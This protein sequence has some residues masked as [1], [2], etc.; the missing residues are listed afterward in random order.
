[1]DLLE[2][3]LRLQRVIDALHIGVVRAGMGNERAVGVDVVIAGKGVLH[4]LDEHL[5]VLAAVL[6][7]DGHRAAVVVQHLDR[8]LQAEHVRPQHRYRRAAAAGVHEVEPIEHKGRVGQR[9]HRLK[10]LGDLDRREPLIAQLARLDHQQSGT[11]RQVLRI[12]DLHPTVQ[13]LGRQ[14]RAA[15]GDGEL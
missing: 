2:D 1:M 12:H 5:A 3:P 4:I 7:A 8:G 15:V 13:L 14:R 9:Y 10:P 6:L 11:G